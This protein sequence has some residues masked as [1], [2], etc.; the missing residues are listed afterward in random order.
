MAIRILPRPKHLIKLAPSAS[1]GDE[2]F[3]LDER[4]FMIYQQ[5]ITE[6]NGIE[7][8]ETRELYLDALQT[9]ADRHEFKLSLIER[10]VVEAFN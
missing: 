4:T 9:F 7:D 1:L 8:G 6:A 5:I 3:S 2:Q 10:R